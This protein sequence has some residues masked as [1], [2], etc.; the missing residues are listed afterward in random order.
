MKNT[1]KIEIWSDIMCP[2]CYIGKRKFEAALND[3]K[4]KDKVEVIWKSYQLSPDLK[5]QPEKSI[6][7]FLAKHKGFSVEEAKQMNNQVAQMAAGEGLTF[8]YDDMVVANSF[9]AHRFAHFAKAHG[10]QNEAE[11]LLFR[12]H[13]TDGKNIDDIA[14]LVELGKELNL[15]ANALQKSLESDD[16]AEDVKSDIRE[17]MEIGVRGV[18]FFVFNRKYAVSGAQSSGVFLQTLEKS[19][20]EWETENQNPLKIIDGQSCDA[21][22][23]CN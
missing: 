4:N 6:H 14:T 10:K 12:S 17:A 11:E 13:F 18:P 2:F 7:Q 9:N 8:N 3:F 16:F 23:N 22:G 1:M 19:Y 5:T 21:D 15:D 20:E